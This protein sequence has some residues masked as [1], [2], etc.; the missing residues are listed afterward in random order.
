MKKKIKIGLMGFGVIGSQV[1]QTLISKQRELGEMVGTPIELTKIKVAP[2]DMTKPLVAAIGQELF[3]TEE[4]EFFASDLNVVI[5][6]IGGELPALN[7]LTRALQ[8]GCH[9]VTSNKEVLA[10]NLA[11][12]VSL[13]TQKQVSLR[14]E[15][16][17]GGG[18]PLLLPLQ[19]G[20]TANK[21]QGISA[22]INGTSN[23]ILSRM[24]SEDIGYEECLK[25][26]QLLGYA[27]ANPEN[28][29]EGFDAAYKLSIMAS[30]AFGITVM[31]SEVYCEGIT[32]LAQA[33]FTYAADMGYVIRLL[34]IAKQTSLGISVRVHPAFVPQDSILAKVDGVYNAVLFS[35]DLV[36]PVMFMGQGAGAMATTSAVIG[37][38]VNACIDFQNQ[39]HNTNRWPIRHQKKLVNIEQIETR[40]Y[41][42]MLIADKP[43]VL[44]SV[45]K[46][47]GD[48]QI[49]IASAIQHQSGNDAEVVMMTH[50]ATEA[51]L[52]KAIAELQKINSVNKIC[53]V[54]RVEE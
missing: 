19:E 40:Y 52:R 23:Y 29:V 37:D 49:S 30:L 50:L 10:K 45:A 47:L 27:E 36:G 41:L 53:N 15:A 26:A 46:C 21:I 28:D 48:N 4:D 32:K 38:V 8:N 3:T 5:E 51:S 24:R 34:A 9:V 2:V 43:G 22:I 14:A 39:T 44:A 42:R 54:I 1:A 18:I 20:L 31:P 25:D 35:G 17:V 13:A 16:S 7:Y 6:V 33:D 12:L 11:K